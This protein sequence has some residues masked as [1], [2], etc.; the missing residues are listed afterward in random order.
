MYLS[1]DVVKS[2]IIAKTLSSQNHQY[3]AVNF[4]DP[5]CSL[6]YALASEGESQETFSLLF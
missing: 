2:G 5:R 1:T 6:C 4:S 3:A